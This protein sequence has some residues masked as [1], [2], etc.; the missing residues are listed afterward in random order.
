[1]NVQQ[2]SRA[3]VAWAALFGCLAANAADALTGAASRFD[4]NIELPD[5][6]G[7]QLILAAC[8][9]CH[10]LQGLASY[11][12]YWGKPQWTAMVETMVQNGAVLTPQQVDSVAEYL[13]RHFGKNNQ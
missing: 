7:K 8:T 9:R 4:P 10:E 11:K 2:L 13:A 12:G 1:M 3:C 5:D 6:D